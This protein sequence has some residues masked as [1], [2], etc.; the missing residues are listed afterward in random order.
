MTPAVCGGQADVKGQVVR[1]P[2]M[3]SSSETRRIAVF[4]CDG[5]GDEWVAADNIE[6]KGAS[7]LAHFNPDATK[8]EDAE[9]FFP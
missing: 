5:G 8:A 6:T 9:R 2:A 7:P 1:G 4:A 3:S